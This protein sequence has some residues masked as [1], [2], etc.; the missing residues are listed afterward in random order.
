MLEAY[1]N[2]SSGPVYLV[3]RTGDTGDASALRI[4]D[5]K[6]ALIKQIKVAGGSGILE[7]DVRDWN[8]G[9]YV[10]ELLHAAGEPLRV[11]LNVQ[12]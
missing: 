3:Y 6:G 11:K 7:V 2:P 12:P 1:P 5:A 4:V 9:V 10:V 8:A